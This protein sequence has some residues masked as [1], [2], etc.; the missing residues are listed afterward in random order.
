MIVNNPSLII[1]QSLLFNITSCT[2]ISY[3]FLG[4]PTKPLVM[5][6]SPPLVKNKLQLNCS[7]SSTTVPTN[8]NILMT[9]RWNIDGVNITSSTGRYIV[10]GSRITLANINVNDSNV[11]ITCT[12]IEQGGLTSDESDKYTLQPLCKSKH[13]N[14]QCQSII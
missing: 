10:R 5:G 1:C 6:L 3:Y 7:T 13:V 9:Y 14:K 8:H 11:M 2:N 4:K 12:G